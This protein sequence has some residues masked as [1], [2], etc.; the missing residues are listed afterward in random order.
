MNSFALPGRSL[1]ANGL[2]DRCMTRYFVDTNVILRLLVGD[3]LKQKKQALKWFDEARR[4][5]KALTI[6][7]IVIAEAVFVLESFY[8]KERLEIAGIMKDFVSNQWIDIPDRDALL[9][10]WPYYIHGLHFV[11]SFLI[12]F[13]KTQSVGIL[14][15]DKQLLSSL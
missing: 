5:E 2:K 7:T 12:A 10:M 11:D 15:F 9:A 13:S 14:S 8:E 4:G 6:S 3:N 1:V